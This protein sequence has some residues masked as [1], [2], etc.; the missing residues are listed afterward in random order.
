MIKSVYV[1]DL[2]QFQVLQSEYKMMHY[3]YFTIK[4]NT[5]RLI[6]M[7]IMNF[8]TVSFRNKPVHNH[9]S[10]NLVT[11]SINEFLF[12]IFS[13]KTSG[14]RHVCKGSNRTSTRLI[15]QTNNPNSTALGQNCFLGF[16][17]S[18]RISRDYLL[19]Q[20]IEFFNVSELYFAD[21]FAMSK[22]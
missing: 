8:V 22:E 2:P 5:D 4:N 3:F 16:G 6:K 21:I 10:N 19:I 11:E 12:H 14:H 20:Y 13:C 17:W 15:K 9:V 1:Y 18:G 7:I